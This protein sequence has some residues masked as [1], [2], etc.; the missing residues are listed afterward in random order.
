MRGSILRLTQLFIKYSL[1]AMTK[2][3]QHSTERYTPCIAILL[4]RV[5]YCLNGSKYLI[6][7]ELTSENTTYQKYECIKCNSTIKWMYGKNDMIIYDCYMK[8][9][10][11]SLKSAE[12]TII[13]SSKLEI[14]LP[15]N[16]D[17]ER[18]MLNGRFFCG[19]YKMVN[20]VTEFN[21]LNGL[22][23]LYGERDSIMPN[24]D[25][26][27]GIANRWD[28]EDKP[29]EYAISITESSIEIE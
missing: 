13:L 18:I 19:T 12:S 16:A 15:L 1:D 24:D 7:K 14:W 29:N 9:L 20:V 8:D 10:A 27:N 11:D 6:T 23:Y 3:I 21:Y 5:K 28:Y 25:V 22:C 4:N 17:S 2:E 26:V